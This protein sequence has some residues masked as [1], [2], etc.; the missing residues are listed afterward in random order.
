MIKTVI[1]IELMGSPKDHIEELI[2]KI[3]DNLKGEDKVK[4]IKEKISDT[5]EVKGFWSNFAELE[6]EVEDIAA[7]VDICFDYMPSS[8]EILEPDKVE[9]DTRYMSNFV[10]DLL[11]RLHKYD[12]MLKN[13]YAENKLLKDRIGKK[14]E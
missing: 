9:M 10:N 7:L 4:I 13:F 11:A 5:I 14:K 1:I 2:K 8:I 6:I 3:V 12:M